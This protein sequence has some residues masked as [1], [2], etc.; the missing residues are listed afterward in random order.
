MCP[1]KGSDCIGEKFSGNCYCVLKERYEK[2]KKLEEIAKQEEE[3]K[4]RYQ[5]NEREN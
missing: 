5:K 2:Q 3:Y 1:L 4:S